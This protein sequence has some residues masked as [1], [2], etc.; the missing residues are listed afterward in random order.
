MHNDYN[1]ECIKWITIAM[2]ND[3]NYFNDNAQ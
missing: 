1:E 3:Y 2:H